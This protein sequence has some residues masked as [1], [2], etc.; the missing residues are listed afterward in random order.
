MVSCTINKKKFGL[1]HTDLHL[2]HS[3]QW[4]SEGT[5]WHYAAYRVGLA[6]FMIGGITAHIIE[7]TGDNPGWK[8]LIYMTNQVVPLSLLLVQ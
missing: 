2:F 7:F 5:N 4:S 6:L 8:W 3:S 1:H